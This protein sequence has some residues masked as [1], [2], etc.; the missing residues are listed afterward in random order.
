[1]ASSWQTF[2]DSKG[3]MYYYNPISQETSWQKP[4]EG[5][6]L[7]LQLQ[8]NPRPPTAFSKVTKPMKPSQPLLDFPLSKTASVTI[9][10]MGPRIYVCIQR[11]KS[12]QSHSR[13][14]KCFYLNPAEWQELCRAGND[15]QDQ[16]WDVSCH[17]QKRRK[18]ALTSLGETN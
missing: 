12:R 6:P 15:I 3:N 17:M 4:I 13:R 2:I 7:Q 8:P 10:R 11:T 9:K 16:L 1:M 5:K 14:G 18:E